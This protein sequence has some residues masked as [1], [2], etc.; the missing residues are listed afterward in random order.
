[1]IYVNWIMCGLNKWISLQG[2]HYGLG[3]QGGLKVVMQAKASFHPRFNEL[4]QWK[5]RSPC[6]RI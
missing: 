4:T 1:M 3:Q 5:L 2:L 6:Q